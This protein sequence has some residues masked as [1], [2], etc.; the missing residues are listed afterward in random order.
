MMQW[1]QQSAIYYWTIDCLTFI[2]VSAT[3]YVEDLKTE[4]N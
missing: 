3:K 1:D 2:I 4:N